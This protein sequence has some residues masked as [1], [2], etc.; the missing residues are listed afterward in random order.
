MAN[1]EKNVY[2]FKITLKGSIPPIWRR[3]QVPENYSFW[4]LHV[5]IQDSMGWKDCHLHEFSITSTVENGKEVCIGIP[6]EDNVDKVLKGW[7]VK[8]VTIFHLVGE[9][10]YVYDFGDCWRHLVKLEKIL[11]CEP[12]IK[13][14]VC[15]DGERACPPEDSHGIDGYELLLEILNDPK[16]PQYKDMKEW[17]GK[18]P[19][20]EIFDC[21]KVKFDDPQKRLKRFGLD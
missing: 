21:T 5:A 12:G 15:I 19:K 3:I 8:I 7:N 4:D 2:Q 1:K 16:H 11:P 10:E 17:V 18:K 14:P 13:Y 9:A 20:P 6:Y